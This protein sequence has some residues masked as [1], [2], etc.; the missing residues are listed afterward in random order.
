M[1]SG[2]LS[3]QSI[4]SIENSGAYCSY[5]VVVKARNFIYK[6]IGSSGGCQVADLEQWT[7]SQV[8]LSLILLA[9]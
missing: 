5:K 3:H 4:L 1:A 2:L 9:M 8:I 7:G 6:G